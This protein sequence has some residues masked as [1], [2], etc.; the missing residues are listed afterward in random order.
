LAA[1]PLRRLIA[2]AAVL[3]ALS[4]FAHHP[5]EPATVAAWA[6]WNLEPWL[7]GLLLA[8]AVLY[9]LGLRR[10]WSRAGRGRG[11]ALREALAF[12]AGWLVLVTA[13]VSPVDTLGGAL[14]SLH[15]VQHELLMVVAAPLLALSRPLEAWTWALEPEWRR[16]LAA[17]ARV[18]ILRRGW[19][20]ATEPAGAW[21]LHA[22][23]L[24]IWHVPALFEA[25]LADEALH[26]VQHASFFVSALFFWWS[27][28]ARGAARSGG[29]AMAS[30]FTTMLHTAALGALLTFAP[31]PWYAHYSQT[32]AF[33]LSALEDLQLGGL[34]LGVPG[35]LAYLAAV[36]E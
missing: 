35:G 8:C 7:V 19:H 36:C 20:A 34:V 18:R 22:A 3:P 29:A 14:F 28:L 6:R 12:A 30:L 23:A 21:C 16:T 24:W 11:I 25:A 2:A 5:G 31:T 9:A 13:L 15:M 27:V 1:L 10:L 4:A 17:A 32:A 33:G 26:V